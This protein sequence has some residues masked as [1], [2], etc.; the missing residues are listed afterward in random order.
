MKF[1]YFVAFLSNFLGRFLMH[2][3]FLFNDF[4]CFFRYCNWIVDTV[5]IIECFVYNS[6]SFLYKLFRFLNLFN[7]NDLIGRS[8]NFADFTQCWMFRSSDD[9][10]VWFDFYCIVAFFFSETCEYP[11]KGKDVAEIK[12][13]T[14]I[15]SDINFTSFLILY[16]NSLHNQ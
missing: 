4:Q 15:E 2:V 16:G 3:L 13:W 1:G 11:V 14:E 7:I 6:F 8:N 10:T 9:S 5:I 12:L